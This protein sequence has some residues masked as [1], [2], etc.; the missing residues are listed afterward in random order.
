MANAVLCCPPHH[1]VN[2][3]CTSSAN[4]STINCSTSSRTRRLSTSR[5]LWA[6]LRAPANRTPTANFFVNGRF[7]RHP[8]F[9][10]AVMQA[11]DRMLQ[12][13]TAPIYFIY[14][15]VDPAS[16]DV[17]IHPTKTEIKFENEQAIWPIVQATVREALGRFDATDAI[18]FDQNGA[19]DMPSL[20]TPHNNI[21]PPS[22][23]TDPDYNPFD[24]VPTPPSRS[25][26]RNWQDLC[27]HLGNDS[28]HSGTATTSPHPSARRRTGGHPHGR[29]AQL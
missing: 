8:G 26:Q 5:D 12:P 9:H 15:E 24:S 6:N 25:N 17:N 3:S 16:I 2:A 11:Y 21:T 14:M 22:I 27:K 13:G 28:S 1:C 18:D 23:H 7:M 4:P 20:L 29:G 10:K 19:V